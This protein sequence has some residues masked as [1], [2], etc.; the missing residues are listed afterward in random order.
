MH[1]VLMHF[2]LRTGGVT[3]VVRLQARI[4]VSN[5]HEV[6]VLTGEAPTEPWP[7]ATVV[8]PGLAYD[9]ADRPASP[10]A[11]ATAR[12]ILDT[13][14]HHWPGRPADL[15]HVHNPTLAKNRRMQSILKRLQ[16]E[17]LV[18]LCQIHDLAEDGRPAVYFDESYVADCHYAVVNG[19]DRQ[20]L[21]RAGLKPE[22]VHHLPNAIRP[23]SRST[24]DETA[25]DAPILYPVRAIRRKNIGETLL[26]Q[27]CL[28]S[29]ARLLV[30][31]PPNS[32]QDLPSYRMWRQFTE[33]HRLP[34]GFEAGLRT[35]FK[36]LM[37]SSRYVVTTSINEGFGF[38]F[39]EAWTAGKALWG[40]SLPDICEDFQRCGIRLDH[41]YPH[42]WVPLDWI[43]IE[44]LRQT[45][46]TV[47]R[48]V[49]QHYGA[50]LDRDD[51]EADWRG[52]SAEGQI[53]FGLLSE[54][55]QRQILQR[56]ISDRM[57]IGDLIE[58]NAWLKR[59]GTPAATRDVLTANRTAV[60]TH[61]SE[62]GYA[63]R[64]FRLYTHVLACPVRQQI[65]KQTL[66]AAFFV[67]ERFSLLK[68]SPF[69]G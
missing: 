44:T 58:R 62:S 45:W 6:L 65:D 32:P 50:A 33:E 8:L 43:A 41:L 12:A 17:G 5:G 36:R 21:R 67:P 68:W 29:P 24:P 66:L 64:L 28:P 2:H 25:S 52:I 15:I 35:E 7:A 27:Q 53:D 60:L 1:I 38:T 22:G 69:D 16:R 39:L 13:L 49:A 4:L 46:Q 47:R 61:F 37:A 31:L 19:R 14:T 42:L 20:I 59:F 10:D 63:R 51:V 9:S 34:V 23:L 57:A 18:L 40:R 56:V 55:F 11:A 54:P 26:I 30:T 3:S 48:Q